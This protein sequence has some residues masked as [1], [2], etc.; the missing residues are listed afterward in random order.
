MFWLSVTDGYGPRDKAFGK[1]ERSLLVIPPKI[2]QLALFLGIMEVSWQYKDCKK[3]KSHIPSIQRNWE[4]KYT[5]LF[6]MLL[7]EH[8]K[9]SLEHHNKSGKASKCNKVWGKGLEAI[10]VPSLV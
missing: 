5:T 2:C 7:F 9:S 6:C 3:D 8:Y 4:G 10:S 1:V